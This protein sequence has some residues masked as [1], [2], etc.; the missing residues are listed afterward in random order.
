MDPETNGRAF[1]LPGPE[2]TTA[3]K[4]LTLLADTAG[5]RAHPRAIP[6]PIIAIAGWFN[7][8]A[9]EMHEM[10]YLKTRRLILE[11][12]RYTD[13]YGSYPATP[14][15]EGIRK[16]LECNRAGV[17]RPRLTSRDVRSLLVLLVSP[18]RATISIHSPASP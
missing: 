18:D 3:R 14:Y 6:S 9:H 5:T 1:N 17:A 15:D 12:R 2:E 8:E 13:R 4:W 10:L 7:H 11:G 16:T